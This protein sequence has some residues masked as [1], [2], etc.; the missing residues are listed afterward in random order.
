MNVFDKPDEQDEDCFRLALER[1]RR[2]Q[3][4]VYIPAS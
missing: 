1:K 4:I 2:V 3:S